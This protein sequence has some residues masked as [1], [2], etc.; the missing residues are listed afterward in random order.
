MDEKMEISRDV[1]IETSKPRVRVRENVRHVVDLEKRGKSKIN[2][3]LAVGRLKVNPY[4][5]VEP[6][7]YPEWERGVVR[8]L[9]SLPDFLN[10]SNVSYLFPVGLEDL[11]K[12]FKIFEE[13]NWNKRFKKDLTYTKQQYLNCLRKIKEK[14]LVERVNMWE[15][16]LKVGVDRNEDGETCRTAVKIRGSPVETEVKKMFLH[17]VNREQKF[18]NAFFKSLAEKIERQEVSKIKIELDLESLPLEGK[19]VIEHKN[20]LKEP[21][22]DS[23]V[24]GDDN[25][26]FLVSKNLFSTSRCD[27]VGNVDNGVD[28]TSESLRKLKVVERTEIVGKGVKNAK[29]VHRLQNHLSTPENVEIREL[30][31]ISEEDIYYKCLIGQKEAL[32][33]LKASVGRF[34]NA[35][36]DSAKLL[37]FL[38]ETEKLVQMTEKSFDEKHVK[39]A[40]D[41]GSIN[42]SEA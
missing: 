26:D 34:A 38:N 3:I 27:V 37:G 39:F 2:E 40:D 29:L 11:Q 19:I 20:F 7:N 15:K 23:T 8:N 5:Y 12:T 33:K 30:L 1:I 9:M 25:F 4:Q 24:S 32:K 31:Q 35:K 13:R 28:K 36:Y 10:F 18:T 21:S 41:N 17:Y 14:W 22:D 6:K 16:Y 42:E